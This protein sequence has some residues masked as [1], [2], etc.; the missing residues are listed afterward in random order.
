VALSAAHVTAGLVAAPAVA[1][2]AALLAGTALAIPAQAR[3]RRP[4]FGE[5]F[6]LPLCW[7]SAPI[8]RSA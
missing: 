5:G 2:V 1:P 7:T 8:L 6:L 3:R 4:D